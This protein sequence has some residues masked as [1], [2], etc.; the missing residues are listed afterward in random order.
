VS[1][2]SSSARRRRYNGG[3]TRGGSGIGLIP[4]ALMLV[5]AVVAWKYHAGALPSLAQIRGFF[6]H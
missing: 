2:Y 5:F 4:V 1:D 3:R 6:G